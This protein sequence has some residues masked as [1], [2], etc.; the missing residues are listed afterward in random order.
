MELSVDNN[1]IEK[2]QERMTSLTA[3]DKIIQQ[4]M[5]QFIICNHS[6]NN[7]KKKMK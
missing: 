3:E 5:Y 7:S 2:L 4:G 1:E 6:L